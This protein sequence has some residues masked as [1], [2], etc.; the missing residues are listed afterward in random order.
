MALDQFHIVQSDNYLKE[1]PGAKYQFNLLEMTRIEVEWDDVRKGDWFKVNITHAG[2]L[3]T[4]H[5]SSRPRAVGLAQSLIKAK[6]DLQDERQRIRWD[7]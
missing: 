2:D 5:K 1:P 4:I 7:L 3:V 6:R